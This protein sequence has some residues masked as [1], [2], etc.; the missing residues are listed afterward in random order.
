MCRYGG[1]INWHSGEELRSTKV[2]RKSACLDFSL[3]GVM[4]N[5]PYEPY[6]YCPQFWTED[7]E[8]SQGCRQSAAHLQSAP[9]SKTKSRGENNNP[10]MH[11]FTER[12]GHGGNT[13]WHEQDGCAWALPSILNHWSSF[14]ILEGFFPGA[15][16]PCGSHQCQD[17]ICD[18]KQKTAKKHTS[19]KCTAMTSRT[20]VSVK[21][22][23][24]FWQWS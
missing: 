4:Q 18:S 3:G 17:I 1:W 13:E 2:E 19:G 10:E 15:A 7:F 11:N 12:Q 16:A 5:T 24:I 20:V 23:N 14:V 9:V 22:F 6:R 8:L 21:K